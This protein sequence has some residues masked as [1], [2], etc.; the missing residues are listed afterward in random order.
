[1]TEPERKRLLVEGKD[2]LHSV[3]ELMRPHIGWPIDRPPVKIVECRGAELLNDLTIP[4]WLK[5][6]EVETLGVLVDANGNCEGR[7]DRIR[8]LCE[9]F[10]SDVPAGLPEAGLVARTERGTRLGV[11]IMPDNRRQGMLETFLQALVPEQHR[12]LWLFAQQSCAQARNHGATYRDVHV[13]KATIHTWLAWMD[14]PGKPFGTA[15]VER[16]FDAHAAPAASFLR[17]FRDLYEL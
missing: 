16:L 1:M 6:T 14:P 11:W 9:P 12:G 13:D 10:M 5:S 17:W 4:L 8:Q 3:V 7:W 2:D 15:F